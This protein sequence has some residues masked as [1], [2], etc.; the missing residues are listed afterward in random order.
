MLSKATQTCIILLACNLLQVCCFST[1]DPSSFKLS[2]N[3]HDESRR[4]TLMQI[5]SMV[6]M[7]LPGD[8]L[9]G[10]CD[11]GTIVAEMQIPGAY[12]QLCM[13]LPSRTITLK[14]I[15]ETVTVVQGAAEDQSSG[16][17]NNSSVSG[18][19]GVALWNR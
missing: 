15:G 9:A 12:Q 6:P 1:N 13:S 14:S 5:I 11:D 4:K 19:T 16:A 7:L 17:S 3:H 10:E 2:S 18:R 8:V